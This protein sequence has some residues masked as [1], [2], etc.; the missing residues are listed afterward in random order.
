MSEEKN[1]PRTTSYNLKLTSVHKYRL[2]YQ[3]KNKE[4]FFTKKR[5]E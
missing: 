5:N 4:N 1:I 3:N 2:S